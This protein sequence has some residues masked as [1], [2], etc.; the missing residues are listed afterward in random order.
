M[1]PFTVSVSGD[2]LTL[3]EGSDPFVGQRADSTTV[4]SLFLS[5]ASIPY[6]QRGTL[7]DFDDDGVSNALEYALNLDPITSDPAGLPSTNS[8]G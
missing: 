6:N 8:S 7:D 4:L 2:Q 1:A 5:D 3:L